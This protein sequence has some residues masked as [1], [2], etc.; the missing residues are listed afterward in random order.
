MGASTKTAGSSEMQEVFLS[1]I[2][3]QGFLTSARRWSAP[4]SFL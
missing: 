2:K 4:C 3:N 1:A